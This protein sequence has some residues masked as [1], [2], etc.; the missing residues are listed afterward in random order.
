MLPKP[1][2]K[3]SH[4]LGRTTDNE[5]DIYMPSCRLKMFWIKL[6]DNHWLPKL[7]IYG[8]FCVISRFY[9]LNTTSSTKHLPICLGI[10]LVALLLLKLLKGYGRPSIGG[11]L[12]GGCSAPLIMYGLLKGVEVA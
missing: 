7:I 10:L 3:N 5:I 2:F 1:S 12:G 11:G 8:C 6:F 9:R 4:Q